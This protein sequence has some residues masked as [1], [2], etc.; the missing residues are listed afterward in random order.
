MTSEFTYDRSVGTPSVRI[1]QA[2]R[3][4]ATQARAVELA[5]G[6]FTELYAGGPHEADG[7]DAENQMRA[8]LRY[9]T[10]MR[11]AALSADDRDTLVYRL[12]EVP[13]EILGQLFLLNGSI[14]DVTLRRELADQN[15]PLMTFPTLIEMA[16]AG[17]VSMISHILKRLLSESLV[18]QTIEETSNGGEDKPYYGDEYRLLALMARD[19]K[20]QHVSALVRRCAAQARFGQVPESEDPGVKDELASA[21]KIVST[22]YLRLDAAGHDEMNK[23]VSENPWK[24]IFLAFET[25]RFNEVIVSLFALYERAQGG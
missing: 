25:L 21:L 1:D 20:D 13:A 18:A 19:E 11:F 7:S 23:A 22:A 8:D 10:V 17:K 16:E 14:E 9:A 6:V 24:V 3:N 5:R 2:L 4:P 12:D 15:K